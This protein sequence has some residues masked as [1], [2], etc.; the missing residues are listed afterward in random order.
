MCAT[1]F[2]CDCLQELFKH[3]TISVSQ[4][5]GLFPGYCLGFSIVTQAIMLVRSMGRF[6][7]RIPVAANIALPRA[8]AT[9][10]SPASPTPPGDSVFSIIKT[11][12]GGVSLMRRI[13]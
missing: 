9:G 3:N 4:Y 12:I 11:F 13:G 7:L 10:G 8:G 5:V 2:L 6:R 1:K